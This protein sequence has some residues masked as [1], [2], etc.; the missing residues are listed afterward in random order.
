MTGIPAGAA[1]PTSRRASLQ[2]L[3]TPR[4][5]LER[6]GHA[7]AERSRCELDD[8]GADRLGWPLGRPVSAGAARVKL[9]ELDA[10]CE[11]RG[12]GAAWSRSWP[13]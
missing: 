7:V 9:A 8:D 11:Q 3:W 1:R 2:P 10:A 6:T 4:E 5:R 13:S 12:R